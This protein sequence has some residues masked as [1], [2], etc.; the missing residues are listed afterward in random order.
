M[1]EFAGFDMP[2]QYTSIVAEHEATRKAVGLF[3]ISHMGRFRFDG[4]RADQLL[5]HLL[6]RRVKDMVPGRFGTV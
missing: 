5:D 1:A 4:P 2:I 6:T 3:D